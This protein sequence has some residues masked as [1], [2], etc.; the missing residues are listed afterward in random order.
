MYVFRLIQPSTDPRIVLKPTLEREDISRVDGAHAYVD[1]HLSLFGFRA[2]YVNQLHRG[3]GVVLVVLGHVDRFLHFRV[4][5]DS[6]N[7]YSV[8]Y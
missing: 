3:G 8:A 2:F 4:A 5:H 1:K 7:H 6:H